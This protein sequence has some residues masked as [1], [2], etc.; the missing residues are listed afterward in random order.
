MPY[1]LYSGQ[2]ARCRCARFEIRTLALSQ[3]DT[4]SP[5][6]QG[7][8]I[9]I[10][11]F[12]P[13]AFVRTQST[14]SNASKAMRRRAAPVDPS[15]IGRPISQFPTTSASA[16]RAPTPPPGGSSGSNVTLD[17]SSSPPYL[18][19]SSAAAQ[20]AKREGKD[21]VQ[22]TEGD[23]IVTMSRERAEGMEEGKERMAQRL[24]ERRFEGHLG[25]TETPKK[26]E[27]EL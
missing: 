26:V 22:V 10:T 6:Q 17:E 15:S 2:L 5:P 8:T 19:E 4:F 14:F 11:K 27:F 12:T 21:M 9:P 25:G 20:S 3:A 24:E 18:N 13:K 23:K 16:S 7:I 1:R